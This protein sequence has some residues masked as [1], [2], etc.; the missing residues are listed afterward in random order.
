MK[1]SIVSAIFT[2]VI[3]GGT[4]GSHVRRVVTSKFSAAFIPGGCWWSGGF[5]TSGQCVCRTGAEPGERGKTQ[6]LEQGVLGAEGRSET[7]H[8]S[9]ESGSSSV[10]KAG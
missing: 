1:G 8:V 9:Q 4:H 2:L 10:R 6:D 5:R 3:S 7:L